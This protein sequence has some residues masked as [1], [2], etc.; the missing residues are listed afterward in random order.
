[1][2]LDL[3]L[4]Q[5]TAHLAVSVS[6]LRHGTRNEGYV[7]VLDD[8][9]DLLKAQKAAAWQEVAQRIAHEIKNPLTPIQLSADR[10]RRYLERERGPEAGLTPRTRDLIAQCASLIAQEVHS[11][12]VL[13]DEFS[14][15]ARFPAAQPSAVQLNDLVRDT[16]ALY[17]P[18]ANGLQL[19]AELAAGLP[20]V[21]ADPALLRRVLVNLVDNA[22]DAVAH[23]PSKQVQVRTRY[24]EQSDS[25]ELSVTDTGVGI[26]PEHKDRLFLPFFST[27]TSGS[28]LGLAIVSRIVAEHQGT[29]RVEDNAPE[30]TRV[31]VELPTRQPVV[32]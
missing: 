31:V 25:V 11:L 14:Q 2:P 22:A 32:A 5:R 4:P 3:P 8:L 27:K 9:S 19:S 28:G 24:K 29:V 12:K 20:L 13:V 10:I 23:S 18:P 15:F 1:G 16:L 6:C 17:A 21:H 26:A 30:G 7:L